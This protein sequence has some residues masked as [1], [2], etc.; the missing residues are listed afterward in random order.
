[1]SSSIFTS[2]SIASSSARGSSMCGGSRGVLSRSATR[3]YRP[4]TGTGSGGGGAAGGG[5]G[6]RISGIARAVSLGNDMGTVAVPIIG[7]QQFQHK[8]GGTTP[9]G[10][11]GTSPIHGADGPVMRTE[12][13]SR[14]G[15]AAYLQRFHSPQVASPA[16]AAGAA[17]AA[18]GVAT[19]GAAGGIADTPPRTHV[20]RRSADLRSNLSLSH[21]SSVP[22]GSTD[23]TAPTLARAG[24]SGP[25]TPHL[26]ASAS[27]PSGRGGGARGGGGGGE[28]G[29]TTSSPG[30]DWSEQLSM[31]DAP[32]LPGRCH[33]PSALTTLHQSPALTSFQPCVGLPRVD[34]PP[35]S[36]I[37]YLSSS[38]F[39]LTAC[40]SLA[41]EWNDLFFAVQDA[42]AAYD[43]LLLAPLTTGAL[44]RGSE[45]KELQQM[46]DEL[47]G[48]AR[49][50]MNG[51]DEGDARRC[52]LLLVRL[53]ALRVKQETQQ[54]LTAVR[55]AAE[56]AGEEDLT[57]LRDSQELGGVQRKVGGEAAGAAGE[58]VSACRD[59][60][61]EAVSGAGG[62]GG[63][64]EVPLLV[65]P[66]NDWARLSAECDSNEG[67]AL[68]EVIVWDDG[69]GELRN[70][71]KSAA[72][73]TAAAAAAAPSPVG[74]AAGGF[75]SGKDEGGDESSREILAATDSW[76]PRRKLGEGGFGC[77]Y[78]GDAANGEVWAVKRA[79]TVSDE[80]LEEFEKEVSFMSRM[81][82]QHLVR[83]IGFWADC[84][85]RILVY[86]FMHSGM[87]S[88]R[89]HRSASHVASSHPASEAHAKDSK[90]FFKLYPSSASTS[91]AASAAAARA[92]DLPP[93]LTFDERVSIAVGAAE[94]LRYL[95][96]FAADSVIHRDIKSDNIL[97]TDK[98]QAKIAD[99]G[100]LKSADLGGPGGGGAGV[101]HT[102]LM[103][104][105][106]YCDPEYSK[107]YIASAKSDVYSFGVVLLE[108]ITGQRAILSENRKKGIAGSMAALLWLRPG[109]GGK[110]QQQKE[111]EM[112]GFKKNK[113]S[114]M[115]AITTLV[116]WAIPLIAAGKLK[117][118]VDPALE[119]NYPLGAMKA[120]ASVA[121]MCVQ[122]SAA[123]RPS[124]AEVATRL[125]A[126]QHKVQDLHI[127]GEEPKYNFQP[128]LAGP[129]PTS[130]STG[131]GAAAG[132][133]AAGAVAG[134]GG[135]GKEKKKHRY[136]EVGR[137]AGSKEGTG[138]SGKEG[139]V[140]R[141]GKGKGLS[142]RESSKSASKS[143]L[144]L[145]SAGDAVEF[146]SQH[147]TNRY[148]AGGAGGF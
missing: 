60:L 46:A 78:R 58:G 103:G 80:Q 126:I 43:T 128:T 125:S 90:P 108:L 113:K 14:A 29:S 21:S 38:C 73:A 55:A 64:R 74:A 85:E 40:P 124:M 63:G 75:S 62:G 23:A 106:G 134:G 15:A 133:A 91:K 114:S 3:P 88:S 56:G 48:M 79:N 7:K 5:G 76:D 26:P 37:V 77:V 4:S 143:S 97:L 35:A 83:L 127:Q 27:V 2:S 70:L 6:G 52:P 66:Q 82:H 53:F 138:E 135:S 49:D 115:R 122:K 131:G 59:G 47:A 111:M 109:V 39:D 33:L 118:V 129:L 13:F 36:A 69:M 81:A 11:K 148:M 34:L 42:M 120:L 145:L 144:P 61:G 137:P 101:S 119:N 86:E 84:D 16:P 100:L 107:T 68:K 136:Q 10:S 110:T 87:L 112:L 28:G 94:G 92:L 89:L 9:G 96:D 117:S 141:D 93:P 8:S 32:F 44:P 116:S 12:P 104:T 142:R 147:V 54:L 19:A 123:Q 57:V 95:H 72:A 98:L 99:F 18:G 22:D 41:L 25:I 31:T 67:G 146:S 17:A 132:G 45:V 121:A 139:A 105:P 1:M 102:R 50:R 30:R 24:G 65:C 51:S 20:R 71:F 130:A 140:G